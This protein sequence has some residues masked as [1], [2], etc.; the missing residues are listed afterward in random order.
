MSCDLLQ[1]AVYSKIRED[2]S[3]TTTQKILISVLMLQVHLDKKV[4]T[5]S[6]EPEDEKSYN[7]QQYLYFILLA[8]M[9]KPWEF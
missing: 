7:K 2:D 1:N 8:I 5:E 9:P 6:V 3:I 4:E